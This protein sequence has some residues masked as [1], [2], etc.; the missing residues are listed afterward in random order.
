MP[1]LLVLFQVWPFHRMVSVG[2]GQS[3]LPPVHGPKPTAQALV[4][5]VAVTPRS[6]SA[7]DRGADTA[8]LA[9]ALPFQCRISGLS[10]PRG[11]SNCPTAHASVTNVPHPGPASAGGGLPR[12]LPELQIL[13]GGTVVEGNTPMT[14][15]GVLAR[16]VALGAAG[17][18]AIGWQLPGAAAA[19]SPGAARAR[20]V[21]ASDFDWPQYLHGPQHS[22]VSNATAITI[23]NAG[24]L[25]ELWHW[26]PPAISG[27]PAPALNASPSVVSGSVYIGAGSGVFYRLSEATGTVTWSRQLDIT[28]VSKACGAR[29]ITSTAAV[30][31]D[32]VTGALTA[33]VSGARYLYALDAATGA[34]EWKTRIG[35]AAAP[36]AYYNWSSPTVVDGHIYV[37]LSSEC[38]TPLIRGG[39]VELDQHN[40]NVLHTW[41]SVPAGSIGGSIWSSAAVSSTGSDVWLSTGNE[42]DPTINTCP[43]GNKIGHSLSVVHLSASLKLLQAWQ[44]PGTAGHGHDWDFGSSPTL[45]GST[46]IPPDVGACNKDGLFYALAGHPLGSSPVWTDTIGA[47][48][49]HTASCIASA[50]WDYPAGELFIGG[51]GTTISG[52]EFGG[53]VRQVD[54]STGSFAWQTG[55]PCA[56]MGT[57]AVDR[58]GV[59]AA[60]TYTCPQHATPGAYLLNASTG[61]ILATLP[62]GPAKVFGQPVFAQDT[63]LVATVSNGLYNFA[64]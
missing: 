25:S 60:G 41:Y 54:P 59:L 4:A 44:A 43:P 10:K 51:D 27:D 33:Y 39:E 55:L 26:Q 5:E 14:R 19:R 50:V 28:P 22:S 17:V 35:P 8:T 49:G 15:G 64:P 1:G 40:G 46:G 9:H 30:L 42:C 24:A 53:S 7:F 32:P 11:L 52:T 47:P 18:V 2:E 38:D 20:G 12:A 58:A 23:A 56:V 31:P 34:I 61:A 63:L 48:A 16:L 21:A 3:T 36:G 62:T 57:P 13:G 37:G 29:G 6:V 45:F